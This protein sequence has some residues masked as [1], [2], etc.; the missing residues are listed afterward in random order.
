MPRFNP[1]PQEEE[2][3]P[4]FLEVLVISL[5]L[6]DPDNVFYD[7]ESSNKN[8]EHNLVDKTKSMSDYEEQD[9]PIQP[10]HRKNTYATQTPTEHSSHTPDP[11]LTRSPTVSSRSSSFYTAPLNST[12]T[13]STE[14]LQTV[15]S[16]RLDLS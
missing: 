9:S 10:L 16:S 12:L 4:L 2:E 6:D 5:G 11:C 14:S 1:E 15:H 3:I 13:D 8:E 7:S